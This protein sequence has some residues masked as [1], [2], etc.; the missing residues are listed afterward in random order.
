MTGT[1]KL[2]IQVMHGHQGVEKFEG[3]PKD[4]LTTSFTSGLSTISAPTLFNIAPKTETGTNSPGK[5]EI[6]AELK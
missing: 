1:S 2:Q 3:E 4:T 5:Y 6:K